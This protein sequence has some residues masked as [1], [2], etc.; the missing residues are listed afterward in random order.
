M[1]IENEEIT[2]QIDDAAETEAAPPKD[3]EDTTMEGDYS[4]AELEG[5]KGYKELVEAMDRGEDADGAEAPAEEA[6]AE[7]A[8]AEEAPAPAE[9]APQESVGA[10]EAISAEILALTETLTSIETALTDAENK[11]INLGDQLENGEISQAKYD[12]EYRRIVREIEAIEQ[13]QA[14]AKSALSDSETRLEQASV[15]NDPWIQA[16]T[17]FLAESGNDIFNAGE[18]HEGLKQA[19]AFASSIKPNEG[20]S[21]A[22]IIQIAANTYR[23]MA[24]ISAPVATQA[25]ATTPQKSKK[26]DP[27]IPPTLGQRQVAVPNDDDSPYAFLEKL[28]GPTFEAAYAK[29]SEAQ[30]DAY[31]DSL[32]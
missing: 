20:K 2:S 25:P 15:A 26:A 23:Q 17:N 16:A 14:E 3:T 6:E 22:E 21:P 4:P 24:G 19:I 12:I 31:L 7:P 32:G 11:A 9:E 28:S 8:K 13:R 10:E 18:H 5:L 30:R 1:T 29:L 27:A